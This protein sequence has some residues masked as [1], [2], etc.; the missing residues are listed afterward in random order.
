V[1]RSRFGIKRAQARRVTS[2][3]QCTGST[4]AS[5]EAVG[6]AVSQNLCLGAGHERNIVVE[7]FLVQANGPAQFG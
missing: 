5:R 2:G 6:R 7:T 4:K 3:N 1:R